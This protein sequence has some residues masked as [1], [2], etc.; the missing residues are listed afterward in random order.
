MVESLFPGRY[1]KAYWPV[2]TSYCVDPNG[3]TLG[4]LAE[5]TGAWTIAGDSPVSAALP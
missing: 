5:R 1:E 4:E 2:H 3:E